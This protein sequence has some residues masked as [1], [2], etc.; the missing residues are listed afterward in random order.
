M[1]AQNY[2]PD[3]PILEYI[4]N[5]PSTN[6]R[7]PYGQPVCV[8]TSH[9]IT[10]CASLLQLVHEV[11]PHIAAL[12]FHA[13]I[14]DDWTDDTIDQL[15]FC[16]KKYGFILWEGS[17]VLNN[18]VNFMGRGS[19]DWNTRRVLADFIKKKYTSGFLRN[20]SW[21][22]IATSWAPGI[23]V[24]E[25]E[26]DV[27]VPTLRK[28]AREAVATTVKTIQTEIS[29]AETG[30]VPE[31]TKAEYSLSPPTSDGWHE[32][33]SDNVGAALRKS[34]TISVTETVTMQPHVQPEDGIPAPP[35]LARGL[36]LCLPSA[37]DTA[38]T[39]EF[40]QSTVAAACANSDFVIG[41]MTSEPFFLYNWGNHLMDIAFRD[42]SGRSYKGRGRDLL[43]SSPY[44]EKE[45]TLALFS[46]IPPEIAK[47]MDT[48]PID[49]PNQGSQEDAQ[50]DSVRKLYY[51][52]GQAMK[53]RE[54]ACKERQ[55]NGDPEAS[56]A[57]RGIL[58][59]P[60]VMLP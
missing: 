42:G 59:V 24:D 33:S 4:Q 37:M 18:T 58:Q 55:A 2:A 17:R 51:V 3:N 52:M 48:H 23:P 15:T 34:S 9:G 46:L 43:E 60:V 8:L 14:I 6:K 57:G 1:S 30:L 29:A 38:F 31:E 11:G 40:R 20:A 50:P 26:K 13:D 5:L 41:F 56:S 19:S 53:S 7:L 28:A 10:D 49:S 21:S 45:H 25:Q 27:M 44:L 12:Q 35:L 39:F 36:A 54:N 16:A 22:N 32:F 47:G